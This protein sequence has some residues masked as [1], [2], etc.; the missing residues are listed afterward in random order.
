MIEPAKSP[1]LT[2]SDG[3]VIPQVGLGVYKVE[4]EIAGPL[5][6]K[7]LQVGYRLIDTAS[8]YLN[9]SGVGQGI[10]DSGV[11]GKKYLF[12]LSSGWMTLGIATLFEHLKKA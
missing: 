3:N 2:L 11:P 12:R 1:L 8:M 7:A 5:V 4:N 10:V 6:S 9:E